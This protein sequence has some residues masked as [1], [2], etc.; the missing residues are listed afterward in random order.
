MKSASLLV[1]W[2]ALSLQVVYPQQQQ[3]LIPGNSYDIPA[4]LMDK[5]GS[6][7]LLKEYAAAK[8]DGNLAGSRF[9]PMLLSFS[10]VE[11]EFTSLLSADAV[12]A[13][14]IRLLTVPGQNH[15]YFIYS[16]LVNISSLPILLAERRLVSADIDMPFMKPL[17]NAVGKAIKA[18]SLHQLGITGAG[19]KIAILDSGL[20]TEP[21]NPDLPPNLLKK[22]YSAFPAL[23]DNVENKS[24]GH[25][26]HVTGIISSQGTLSSGNTGNGGFAYKGIAP[27]ADLIFLKIGNDNTGMASN[28]AVI[29]ALDAAIEVYGAK[30]ISLSYGGWDTYHD[31]SSPVEQKIDWCYS[32]KDVPVFVAAGNEGNTKRHF[33]GT[34]PPNAS[35]DFI[36]VVY[37]NA[38]FD[39]NFLALNL[40]WSDGSARSNL[41]LKYY[42]EAFQEIAD[43]YHFPATQSP[44]GTESQISQYNAYLPFGNGV[45]YLKVEN[46]SS[47]THRFH[48]YEYANEGIVTFDAASPE[49]TLCSPGSADNAFTVGSYATKT[50]WTAS[51]GSSYSSG[52]QTTN[53]IA[54]YSSQ[55]PRIDGLLK[56]DI[57]A[58]GTAVIS[59]RDRDVFKFSSQ[60]WIDNDGSPGGDANY[61]VMHGTSMATPAVAGTAVLLYQEY[62]DASA[63]DVYNALRTSSTKD[64]YTGNTSNPVF[65]SGKLNAASAINSP[66]LKDYVNPGN[67]LSLTLFA[68]QSQSP[69]SSLLL[70]PVAGMGQASLVHPDDWSYTD[71]YLDCFVTA[72]DNQPFISAEIIISWDSTKAE[73]VSEDGNL[74]GNIITFRRQIN[75][76][77]LQ[78][79]ITSLS[80]NIVPAYGEY[81]AKLRVKILQPG[82]HSFNI[83]ASDV[84]YYD[85]INDRQVP[86]YTLAASGEVTLHYGD[87]AKQVSSQIITEAGDGNVDFA[88]LVGFSAA[89]FSEANGHN[90]NQYRVK[91]DIGSSLSNPNGLPVPNNTIGFDDLFVFASNYG[92]T[93]SSL[94][95]KPRNGGTG[96]ILVSLLPPVSLGNGFATTA[97]QIIGDTEVLGGFSLSLTYEGPEAPTIQNGSSIHAENGL[98]FKK[99]SGNTIQIDCAA[100]NNNFCSGSGSVFLLHHREHSMLQKESFHAVDYQGVPLTVTS[101]N[102]NESVPLQFLLGNNY[103]NPFNPSTN[104]S[105]SIPK[106]EFTTLSVYNILGELVETLFNGELQAG[107]HTFTFNGSA[108]P[109]GIYFCKMQSQS[110][111]A[112]RKMI[113][114]R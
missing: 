21:L 101:V 66:F 26:T 45:F 30:V 46:P 67:P 43:V 69:A 73:L 4:S 20:D 36:K 38:G 78:L 59:L 91:Y 35:S 106:T 18:D 12:K 92:A 54:G 2:I 65:G 84:Q 75:A 88:D 10:E 5:V 74:T 70:T 109:T 29:A 96:T 53:D 111:T 107:V 89:Y 61:Y 68:A 83:S 52:I 97:V 50:T 56:P 55:G 114:L 17:I 8:L 13:E 39:Q 93:P 41:N 14:S 76:S 44:R 80:G 103:P 31:G 85:E 63:S 27:G 81:I 95:Q 25:G 100:T 98:I 15:P 113:M 102:N 112:T 82:Y 3:T 49:Y 110:Y 7:L 37:T 47:S 108:F 64:E 94:P 9:V 32:E 34:V 72:T 16:A 40:V 22:D 1:L 99:I 86:V 19:V 42:D 62:P 11:P 90:S 23:D 57:V 28:A 77:T 24:T 79:N 87:F 6:G 105:V 33:T 60:F 58:P 104:I 51:N 71:A 48:I